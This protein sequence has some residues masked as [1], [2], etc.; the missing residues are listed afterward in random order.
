MLGA[1]TCFSV[2]AFLFLAEKPVYY[3]TGKSVSALTFIMLLHCGSRSIDLSSPKVMGVLNVTPDSFFDGGKH[4]AASGGE[5]RL[6]IDHAVKAAE[7]MVLAG[8]AFID[9]G[10]E[11]TRPGAADVS[12]QQEADRVLPVVEALASRVDAVVS[13]DTSTALVMV[14]ACRLG[15]G[16]LNDVRA[17]EREGALAA[18]ITTGLPICLMHMQGN[19]ATMQ[20]NPAYID[21]VG[22]VSQYLAARI[23]LVVD[24]ASELGMVP[25]QL[26][27]DPGFGFGKTDNH[28]I[29]LLNGL[30][31]LSA[32]RLPLLVG[33]SRKSMLGRL[34][35]RPPSERLAGSL[36]L[37][38]IAAQNGAN[39]I[40]VHDV[41]ETMDVIT[42]LQQVK[43]GGHHSGA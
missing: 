4:Y 16:L 6:L 30:T 23:A 40:R 39:I 27:L 11:S 41:P 32:L 5:S 21:V 37:A 14:E 38:L 36:A 42:L 19:P 1:A 34:L 13:V 35:G 17:L 25:P 7:A 43:N 15:A 12:A 33:L 3:F 20:D 22:D 29:A 2:A 24:T 26:V 10:G 9:V 28:N 18:A 8:A 31:E